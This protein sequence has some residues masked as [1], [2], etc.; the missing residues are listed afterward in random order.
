[1]AFE[2]PTLLELIDRIEQD[3]ISRLSLT[4][5]LLRR[6]MVKIL[7]R[8]V[9]GATHMLHGHLEFLGKQLFP[10]S[11]EAE[12]FLRQAG[13]FG[14]SQNPA[15]FAAGTVDITGDDG[16]VVEAGSVLQRSDG[17]RYETDAEVTIASGTATVAVTAVEAGNDGALTD[18]DALSFESPA[19]GVDASAVVASST[20]DGADQE[21]IDEL[22]TRFL[23]YLRDP[24]QGGAEQDYV[25]WA[26]EVAGVTRVF[27]RPLQLGGGTVVV[28]F[29]RDDDDSGP[30]P[31]GGEVTEVQDYLDIKRPVTAAVT[32]LAPT[33]VALDLTL[34]I[35]PDT[36]ELRAAV[37]AELVD[38]LQRE[39]EPGESTLPISKIRTAIGVTPDLD[40]YVL[41]TPTADIDY[42]TGEIPVLGTIT[43]T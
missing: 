6:A 27:V 36:S 23:E 1:M 33:E 38:L 34:S 16:S 8:V 7:A 29:M 30:I 24:P 40:D 18:G 37:E 25:G 28:Y 14:F 17:I 31:S 35:T 5:G 11:S 9:A 21:T 32:V 20:D 15:T 13:L 2:R 39:A 12:F 26:K 4:A 42:S 22:R 43:W 3:F 10:D 19:A 41:T